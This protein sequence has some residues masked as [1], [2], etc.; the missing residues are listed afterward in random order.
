MGERNYRALVGYDGTEY[1]GFQVQ[2]DRATIQGELERA[3][4][5][6]TQAPVRLACAGRTDAGVHSRGQVVSFRT[7]WSHDPPTLQ[8]ALN[9][10]LPRDISVRGLVVVG[11]GFHARFSAQSRLYAYKAYTSLVRVPLL[12]RFACHVSRSVELCSMSSATAALV[13]ERDFAAFGQSPSGGSTVRI[14]YLA[15]W[16]RATCQFGRDD[17]VCLRFSIEANGFL[18]GMVRRIV[19]TLLQVGLGEAGVSEFRDILASG[20]IAQ[21]GP[22]APAC[23]LCFVGVRYS[24]TEPARL[25]P[26]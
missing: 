13:G 23:G 7:P 2:P 21:A 8:R 5:R 19:G 12:D 22:P 17:L 24:D 16:D 26:W 4:Y 3:L 15:E 6:V 9:A 25:G 11:D 1:S 18:R 10:L 14:V 20:D